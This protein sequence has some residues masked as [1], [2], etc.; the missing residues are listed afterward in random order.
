MNSRTPL[1]A[2]YAILL[3]LTS[4][5]VAA[6]PH[7]AWFTVT[8]SDGTN[9]SPVG[10][11]Q[12]T[13]V[14]GDSV[15]TITEEY[16][17]EFPDKEGTPIASTLKGKTTCNTSHE[18]QSATTSY[19]VNGNTERQLTLEFKNGAYH[20]ELKTLEGRERGTYKD[21][22][23]ILYESSH[24]FRKRD[25][26][27]GNSMKY[28]SHP[29]FDDIKNVPDV[30]LTYHG[31]SNTTLHSKAVRLRHYSTDDEDFYL[32]IDG[33]FARFEMIL[34]EGDDETPQTRLICELAEK[35]EAL[36]HKTKKQQPAIEV[37]DER[38]AVVDSLNLLF[39]YYYFIR[40]TKRFDYV[41]SSIRNNIDYARV[42]DNIEPYFDRLTRLCQQGHIALRAEGLAHE[43]DARR[44]QAIGAKAGF[45]AG[46]SLAAEDPVGLIL[47]L[48]RGV[49][50]F[51]KADAETQKKVDAVYLQFNH[52]IRSDEF[53]LVKLASVLA[54]EHNIND[55]YVVFPDDIK[56]IIETSKIVDLPTRQRR[57]AS[58]A[59]KY[60]RFPHIEFRL[61][62]GMLFEQD[63]LDP[64]VFTRLIESVRSKTSTI[65]KADPVLINAYQLAGEHLLINAANSPNDIRQYGT[66]LKSVADAALKAK[67]NHPEFCLFRGVSSYLLNGFSAEGWEDIAVRST[68]IDNRVGQR[69][70]WLW[71]SMIQGTEADRFTDAQYRD[72]LKTLFRWG[73]TD[74]DRL[75]KITAL[76][77]TKS[78]EA[79]FKQ[80][81]QPTF[82]YRIVY[83]VFNDDI[84]I[85][86]TCGFDA[87]NV[88]VSGHFMKN[89][90]KYPFN[91]SVAY[92]PAG[93]E[94]KAVDIVSIQGGSNQSPI[95]SKVFV[96]ECDQ[97]LD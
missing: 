19:A 49:D 29:P 97:D 47:A 20:Y 3:F 35:A 15:L 40:T 61:A 54:K 39:S 94:F 18:I 60:R 7:E 51:L 9:S 68:D 21:S 70:R 1:L 12:I 23:P 2:V 46:M 43:E 92:L 27:S 4:H 26:R 71:G 22:S 28:R 48:G 33:R 69:L 81:I 44:K 16:V 78:R 50:Q 91:F 6:E 72:S 8:W 62:Q 57:L 95:D 14:V 45:A 80:L 13:E 38:L 52:A 64:T 37:A 83:G 79:V 87:T 58:L 17:V 5:L 55:G 90:K 77:R 10:Y 96:V 85:K 65:A 11:A 30:T 32:N 75:R 82:T 42:P 59:E 76:P 89:G 25:L 73:W 53:D 31:V 84:V 24:F 66:H 88:K 36:A 86:N 41:D 93:K 74:I 63:Q 67:P 34:E 56:T